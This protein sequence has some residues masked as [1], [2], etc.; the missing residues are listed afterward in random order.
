MT[1]A[2]YTAVVEVTRT[3]PEAP[4]VADGPFSD[5]RPAQARKVD[6][7]ARLVIRADSVR[8]LV[9]KVQAHTALLVPTPNIAPMKEPSA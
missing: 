5:R 6:E 9:A 7:V 2:H 1:D 3:T 8:E 4:A